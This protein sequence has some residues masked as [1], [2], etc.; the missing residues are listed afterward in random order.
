M[1]YCF[2]T[3]KH[4]LLSH[5]DSIVGMVKGHECMEPLMMLERLIARRFL[6]A[7]RAKDIKT[8][9]RRLAEAYGIEIA[10]LDI[11]GIE[12]TFSEHLR[13]SFAERGP[14]TS[15][16]TRRNTM[17]NLKQFYRLLHESGIIRYPKHPSL[18]K[19]PRRALLAQARDSSPYRIGVPPSSRVIGA[20]TTNG[21]R[22]FASAGLTTSPSGRL[23]SGRPP[24]RN[25]LIG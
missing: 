21:R 14:D 18:K 22:R 24:S 8:A 3:R 1:L 5:L 25:T 4:L 12:S 13:A 16:Y 20:F 10:D 17:Q 6:P 2:L 15:A 7:S 11:P 23:I 19:L 9:L